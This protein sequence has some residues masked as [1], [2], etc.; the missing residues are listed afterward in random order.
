MHDCTDVKQMPNKDGGGKGQMAAWKVSRG[1][2][3]QMILEQ[4]SICRLRNNIFIIVVDR[5]NANN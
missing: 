5:R 3:I 2:S 1:Q 4:R